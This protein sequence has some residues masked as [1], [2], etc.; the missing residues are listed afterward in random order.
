MPQLTE[1]PYLP[2]GQPDDAVA[3]LVSLCRDFPPDGESFKVFRNR[4]RALDLWD[5]ERLPALQKFLRLE[6]GDQVRPSALVSEIAGADSGSAIAERLWHVNPVLFKT[7]IERLADRVS[8]PG[9]LY[10]YL[11][12][13]AYRGTPVP[14]AQLESWVHLARGLGVLKRIGIALGVGDRAVE[15]F[16]RAQKLD[17]EE[18]LEEDEPEAIAAPLVDGTAGGEEGD[19]AAPVGDA[20]TPIATSR[21]TTA[22]AP[23]GA[24]LAGARLSSPIGTGVPVALAR[25]A[26]AAQLS[27]DILGET[28]QRLEVWWQQQAEPPAGYA[29]EDFGID[30]EAWMSGSEEALYR[31]AVAAA[32]VFRLDAERQTVQAVFRALD[33]A[34]VLADLYYGTAPEVLPD[35]V[36]SK[37]LMLASLVARRC[38]EAPDLAATLEKQADAAAAFTMLDASLGRGLFKI[39]LFWIMGRLRDLGALRFE[40][41]DDYAALPTRLVRDT[42]FR[43]GFIESPYA[44]D[45]NA[46]AV[47]AAAARRATGGVPAPHEVLVGFAV[48]AGCAYDCPNRRGCDVACRERS[49]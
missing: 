30:T 16:D 5:R 13:F 10:S 17:I 38:A 45:A 46:L 22:P 49:E 19:A 1:F 23:I 11:D 9:E 18:F 32:F 24:A 20:T 47:A 31:I 44:P 2:A 27:E 12:S 3:R 37:A 28:A 21:P 6:G 35:G 39:E 4:L 48:A 33:R 8:P 25:F 43:L 26:G 14:R 41:L 40:D 34:N 15:F 29:L 7:I 42:L 36:D